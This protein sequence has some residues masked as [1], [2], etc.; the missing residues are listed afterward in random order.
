MR[1]LICSDGSEQADRAIRVGAAIAI[2]CQAEVTLLGIL[3]GPGKPETILDSLQRGQALLLDKGIRAELVTKAGDPI[4]EIIQRTESTPYDLVVIGAVRKG[5]QGPFLM[6]AK[7]YKIIKEI[8]PPVLLVAGKVGAI[9]KILI[10]SGG[11]KYIEGA[12]RFTAQIAKGLGA[13]VVL[14][15]VMPEP[16]A[17]YAHLRRMEETAARLLASPSEL[18]VNLRE[19]KQ[20]IEAAGV[21]VEVRLRRGSVLNEILNELHEGNYDLVVTGSAP[22]RTFRTYVMGDVTREVVNHTTCAVLVVR[23]EFKLPESKV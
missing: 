9:Q 17:I 3:E 23:S 4:A 18:G 7:A 15:H 20:S 6:S 19:E 21:P 14:L 1:I 13:S 8:V 12:V 2:G 22:N 5:P 11:K 16:P 10:C